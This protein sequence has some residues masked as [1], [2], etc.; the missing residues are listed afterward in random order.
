MTCRCAT[1]ASKLDGQFWS[2]K[3]GARKYR[4]DDPSKLCWRCWI[5]ALVQLDY[6]RQ[7]EL[8]EEQP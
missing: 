7:L 6:E 3:N 4:M 1:C 2:F 5:N 8:S